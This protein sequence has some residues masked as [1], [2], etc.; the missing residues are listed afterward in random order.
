MATPASN[1]TDGADHASAATAAN[2]RPTRTP[3][4]RRTPATPGTAY[5]EGASPASSAVISCSSS[6]ASQP[7]IE[8]SPAAWPGRPSR[9]RGGPGRLI[10][11]NAPLSRTPASLAATRR[12]SSRS[13]SGR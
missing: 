3:A 6:P 13:P 1:P 12:I 7:T 11:E 5:D 10:Q 2:S 8:G 9:A 4:Q